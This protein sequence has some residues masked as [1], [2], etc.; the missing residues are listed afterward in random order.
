[1]YQCGIWGIYRVVDEFTVDDGEG[2]TAK[3][4][5]V[6]VYEIFAVQTLFIQVLFLSSLV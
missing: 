5:G 3:G 2:V 6:E 1:M 4:G